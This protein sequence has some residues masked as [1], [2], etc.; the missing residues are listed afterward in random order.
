MKTRVV[1]PVVLV[2]GRLWESQPSREASRHSE[3]VTA[4]VAATLTAPAEYMWA[5]EHI[6][7]LETAA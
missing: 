1:L 7:S 5:V 4:T 3:V 2:V 6:H